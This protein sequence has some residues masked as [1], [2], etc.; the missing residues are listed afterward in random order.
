MTE[1]RETFSP[2]GN[3]AAALSATVRRARSPPMSIRSAL[4]STVTGLAGLMA[5]AVATAQDYDIVLRGGTVHDGSGGPPVV[6]DLA[7]RG[8]TIA[9]VGD[10]RGAKAR[11]E[12][13]ARGRAVAPGFINMLSWA[14][15]SLL[16]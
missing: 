13:D 7:I 11:R 1:L 6:A 2:T 4:L 12:I 14:P 16:A 8:D 15:D 5:G 10:L 9:A 3:L